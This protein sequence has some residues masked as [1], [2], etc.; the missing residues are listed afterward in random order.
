MTAER[1]IEN[2]VAPN[3][4]RNPIL[5]AVPALIRTSEDVSDDDADDDPGDDDE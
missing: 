1:T 5:I 4:P 2:K 3:A